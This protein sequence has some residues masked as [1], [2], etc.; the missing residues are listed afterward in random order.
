MALR[1]GKGIRES[2]DSLDPMGR[3]IFLLMPGWI[4]TCKNC[5]KRFSH[6]KIEEDKLTNFYLHRKPE[7]PAEGLELECPTC[8]TKSQYQQ[9]DLRYDSTK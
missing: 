8:N 3:R 6:S 7:F 9:S 5:S 4:L 2:T 1:F